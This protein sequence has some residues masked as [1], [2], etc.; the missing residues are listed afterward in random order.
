M[1]YLYEQLEKSSLT[2]DFHEL[3]TQ[4]IPIGVSFFHP[5][6]LTARLRVTYV[7][8]EGRFE[9]RST[10]ATSRGHDE[11]WV[12]DASVSY[13]LPKRFGLLSLEGGNLFDERFRFQDTGT[14]SVTVT[15]ERYVL[16]RFTVAY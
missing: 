9:D 8:Q 15:P 7:D 11:F 13:R 2:F 12:T 6:G 10:G 5:S 4:R 3:R 1:E 16:L 14:S